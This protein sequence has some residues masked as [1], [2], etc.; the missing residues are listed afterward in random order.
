MPERADELKSVIEQRYPQLEV[1]A[2]DEDFH[3]KIWVRITNPATGRE[4]GPIKF[5]VSM[6]TESDLRHEV[7]AVIQAWLARGPTRV[8]THS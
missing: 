5:E 2:G 6:W 3:R 8:A 1:F 7:L 4:L